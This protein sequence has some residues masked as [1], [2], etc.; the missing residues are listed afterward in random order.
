M[1]LTRSDL[2]QGRKPYGSRD[3]ERRVKPRQR[4]RGRRPGRKAAE[5][6][7]VDGHQVGLQ[8]PA[9]NPE[10]DAV[11][12]FGGARLQLD[13]VFDADLVDQLELGLEEVDVILLAFED[14]G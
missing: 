8:R 10:R 3:S 12:L 13:V 2:W 6:G 7:E 9:C 11:A 14:L 1:L 4:A 5:Q